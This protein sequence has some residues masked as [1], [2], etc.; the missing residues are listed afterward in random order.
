MTSS[1]QGDEVVKKPRKCWQLN[2]HS[3]LSFSPQCLSSLPKGK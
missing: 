1:N 2:G 3:S